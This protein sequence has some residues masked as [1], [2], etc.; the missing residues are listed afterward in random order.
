M[1][2]HMKKE[3][4][5]PSVIP[6][7]VSI[8]RDCGKT[9]G[10]TW[11]NP[12]SWW[13]PH[14]SREPGI[15]TLRK[16]TCFKN[17]EAGEF[18]PA[19]AV[20]NIRS[21]GPK[22]R[23]F[24]QDFRMRDLSVSLLTETW[25]KDDR[26]S[27]RRKIIAMFEKEGLGIISLNR[28]VRRGG[29]VAIVFDSQIIDLE[30]LD[31]VVPHNLEVVWGLGR[32]KKGIIKMIIFAAFYYPP[33]AKKKQKMIDHLV[34]T[35]HDLLGKYPNAEICLAGDKNEL[36]LAQ[37]CR[38]IPNLKQLNTEPTYKTKMID[39]LLTTLTKFYKQ[40]IVVDPIRPDKSDAKPSDH[41]EVI[42][43]P[44]DNLNEI[45]KAEYVWKICRPLPTSK[46]EAFTRALKYSDLDTLKKET[47]PEVIDS[48][49]LM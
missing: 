18:L 45:R 15:R 37:V 17:V 32:P 38:N 49:L 3:H 48:L 2:S 44:I 11:R 46:V 10:E 7:T 39:V 9:A 8:G 1:S 21:L 20:T 22:I 24:M 35:T 42:I 30:E 41:R 27:Y 31:V 13:E 16:V 6:V 5:Q 26:A 47:D 12:P 23:S 19:I 36:E 28:K 34:M 29:G 43:Y 14:V 4:V 25:G 33:R 40:P